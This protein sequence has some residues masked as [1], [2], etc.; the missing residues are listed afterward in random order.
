MPPQRCRLESSEALTV[1]SAEVSTAAP[2]SAS[3]G[4][5]AVANTTFVLAASVVSKLVSLVVVVVLANA[6]GP[7]GYGRYTTLIAFS[8]LVSV[9]AAPGLNRSLP[10]PSPL[11][12]ALSCPISSFQA[13]P[14]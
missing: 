10:S 7:D 2:T 9:V 11:T 12:W 14:C 5:R 8:A 6:L 3:L 1:G 13:P 4:T